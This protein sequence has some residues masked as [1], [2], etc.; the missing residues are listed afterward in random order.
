MYVKRGYVPDG[1]GI[2]YDGRVVEPGEQVRV[3]DSL[4]LQLT[5]R[6]HI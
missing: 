6:L 4:T 2:T 3:D 5:K 1:R